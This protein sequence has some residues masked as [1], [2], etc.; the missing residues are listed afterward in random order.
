MT[1]AS[2]P[3]A[4]GR[5]LAGAVG[6]LGLLGRLARV[7]FRGRCLSEKRRPVLD[8][9]RAAAVNVEP[10]ECLFKNVAVGELALGARMGAEVEKPLLEHDYLLQPLDVAP[11]QRQVAEL[12]G[13]AV[14][15]GIPRRLERDPQR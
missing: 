10:G 4:A 8:D 14:S 3:A 11:G 12:R 9:V 1:S 13:L 5:T 7:C 6:G 2:T 15:V